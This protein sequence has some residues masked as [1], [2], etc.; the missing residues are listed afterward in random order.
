[1][2]ALKHEVPTL[3]VSIVVNDAD[4]AA[5]LDKAIARSQSIKQI[6]VKANPET[7]I[8]PPTNG[9]P[10]NENG[11]SVDA[12]YRLQFPT[13]DTGVSSPIGLR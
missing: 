9:K 1:M 3:G 11:G 10:P 12:R 5:R 4:I 8:D 6:E 13:A 7:P 2:A